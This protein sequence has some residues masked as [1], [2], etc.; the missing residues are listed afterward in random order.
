[1]G[2]LTHN[3]ESTDVL[4]GL[5][6]TLL[7]VFDATRDLYQTLTNKDK[8]D[9]ELQLRLKGHPS[10]RKL[11]S[12]DDTK[13]SG[14]RAILTA[15]LAL[16]RRYEDGL[17]DVG[18]EFAVGD[19]LSHVSLQSEVIKL[20]GVLLTTFL[21]GPT[22]SESIQ[23]QLSKIVAA[24]H[25]AATASV[26]ILN[27]LQN[28]QQAEL[29]ATNFPTS[30][31][32][33]LRAPSM[34]G[35]FH[36]DEE[37]LT[38]LVSYREPPR[39][40]AGSPANTTVLTKGRPEMTGIDIRSLTSYNSRTDA[41]S[42]YCSYAQDLE[43]HRSQQL[44]SSI[45]DAST[46]S[47]PDCRRTL[48]LSPGKAWEILKNDTG[49]ERCFQISIRFV[50]KCHRSGPDAGYA[51]ILCS[52]ADDDVTI[53]GDVKALV[54]HVCED[55][56]SA[57]LKAEED[58]TEVVE[59]ALGERRRDSGLGHYSSRSSRRSASV[60]SRRRGS[61]PHVYDREVEAIE[62]RVPRRGA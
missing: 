20:Q 33:S 53:C 52:R 8:R 60:S 41:D 46:P 25:T 3:D 15:K 21:Y 10:S 42:L 54:K 31:R 27:A 28:R 30:R 9:Y 32:G 55:H 13:V 57:E 22:S 50:V 17:R 6:Y 11:E 24:S 34:P 4:Q 29:R 59:L 19:T 38:A 51:C 43:R 45:T 56:K 61:R 1:M 37:Q 18:S 49:Y 44:S 35:S 12:I 47:C 26:D 14:N 2:A 7:D 5:V 16:L 40:R 58:I 62:I 48:H 23:Q 36:S 39:V